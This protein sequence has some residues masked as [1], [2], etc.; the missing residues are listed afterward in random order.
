[1][2]IDARA[3]MTE[4]PYRILAVDDEA[5][6]LENYRSSLAAPL[7]T[8][9]AAPLQAL[10]RDL[11]GGTASIALQ[12]EFTLSCCRSGTH[13]L[14]LIAEARRGDA[15]FTAVL[16][17]K[18]MPDDID[19]LIVAR[20]IRRLDPD[21]IV[22]LVTAAA[23]A[24]LSDRLGA[25]AADERF[26]IFYK[27]FYAA[28]IRQFLSAVCAKAH[29]ERRLFADN[30]A[31][32]AKVRERT[33]ALAAAR[34]AAEAT[35][36]SKSAFLANISHEVRTPLNGILGMAAL[37]EHGALDPDQRQKLAVIRDSGEWLLEIINGLLETASIE[38]GEVRLTREPLDVTDTVR[39]ALALVQGLA[40]GK[41]IAITSRVEIDP[42]AIF[43]GDRQR[44]KQVLTNLLGNAIKFSDGG[45]I[46]VA[47]AH[48]PARRLR[49][50]VTDQGP[51]VAAE[52][53]PRLFERF[54]KDERPGALAS[55]T[56]S[57]GL[58]LAICKDLVELMGGEIG[59]ETEPG[60]GSRF[61]FALP[62]R[63]KNRSLSQFFATGA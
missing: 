42:D 24:R 35:S 43:V 37:M 52:V 9:A 15:P 56:A 7:A 49:F 27:P 17:D 1:M 12:G 19:G 45:E 26:F 18:S 14:E 63:Q 41:G 47:V 10:E 36:L 61:W 22:V 59:V 28:E 30:A 23:D 44:I 8:S 29:L 53:L 39:E 58:G 57:S 5:E 33:A 54:N 38:A 11:Y 50:E 3:E 21:M 2:H 6:I 34:D 25:L 48:D 46:T 16:L 51:G 31:L 40:V 32:E 60:R 62:L 13:A 55:H 20:E 4:P